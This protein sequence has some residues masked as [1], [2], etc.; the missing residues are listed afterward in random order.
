MLWQTHIRIANEVFRRLD[1]PRSSAE[2]ERLREGILSPDKWGDYPHHYGKSKV[3]VKYILE[4]RRHFL[5]NDLSN[6]YFCLGVA[7]HYVQDS[8]TSLSSRSMKHQAWEQQIEESYFVD[9]IQST[10]QWSF[11]KRRYLVEPYSR[12]AQILSEEVR[13]KQDTLRMATLL[14]NEPPSEWGKPIVDLNMAL[15]ASL[16]ITKSV[17][18]HRKNA[19]LEQDLSRTL[20]EYE[21]LLKKTETVFADKLVESIKKR[22][23]SK[24]RKKPSGILGKIRNLFLDIAIKVRD[25]QISSKIQKYDKQQHLGQ[26]VREYDKSTRR[27]GAPHI[28]WYVFNIP[29]INVNVVEKELLSIHETT[30]CFNLGEGTIRDLIE[31]GKLSCYSSKDRDLL[32]RS[33]LKRILS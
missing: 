12:L 8:Y 4:A 30:E 7:L 18:S 10:I 6:A 9:Y 11:Q 14:G 5:I 2:A 17:L 26:V 19:D 27:I 25:F 13:G 3:I 24:K 32:R 15:R 29:K 23:I 20:A 16:Q 28:G 21:D 31:Q 1:I 33:D 22:D